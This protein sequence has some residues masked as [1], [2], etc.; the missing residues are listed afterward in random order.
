MT[1]NEQSDKPGLEEIL[2][3][4]GIDKAKVLKFIARSLT[5]QSAEAA[6][7]LLQM[8]QQDL[9]IAQGSPFY[10]LQVRAEIAEVA[11]ERF[12]RMQ[13]ASYS[14][15]YNPSPV[16]AMA[17][18]ALLN[19]IE[20]GRFNDIYGVAY[21]AGNHELTE[22]TLSRLEAKRE[23]LSGQKKASASSMGY[24]EL[25]SELEV[26]LHVQRGNYESAAMTQFQA[27]RLEDAYKL[28]RQQGVSPEVKW[29]VGTAYVADLERKGRI[30]IASSVA[31]AIGD[32]ETASRLAGQLTGK[33]IDLSLETIVKIAQLKSRLETNPTLELIE[34]AE[35]LRISNREFSDQLAL[36][37]FDAYLARGD[38]RRAWE[39]ASSM[40]WHDR[41]HHPKTEW[42]RRLIVY[43]PRAFGFPEGFP[44]P[45]S[46]NSS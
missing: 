37:I 17:E 42:L 27:G 9:E 16:L 28:S 23:T 30:E 10:E 39:S 34:T 4:P 5:P 32:E 15:N 8:L 46:Q 2:N 11:L 36:I 7:L 6:D 1:S 3:E 25:V 21:K 44:S 18:L 38:Y 40:A 20:V 19:L 29:Q 41:E 14:P 45:K 13:W 24:T 35:N 43:T 12:G 33:M 22:K 26:L 31:K